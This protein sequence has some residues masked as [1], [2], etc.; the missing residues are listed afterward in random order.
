MVLDCVEIRPRPE[1]NVI[2]RG[3]T[4]LVTGVLDGQIE[5][6]S[7]HGL[8]VHETRMLSRYQYWI[9]GEPLNAVTL[10]NVNRSEWA[11]YYI[12]S[13]SRSKGH[14]PEQVIELFVHRFAG[15]GFREDL[16]IVN[17]TQ[18]QQ[19]FNFI[20][21]LKVDFADQDEVES[22][23]RKQYGTIVREWCKDPEP[24]LKFEYSA[25]RS[26]EHQGDFGE[27]T[28]RR[29]LKM[30][31][32]DA[33]SAPEYK[34]EKIIF[35]IELTPGASWKARVRF[36]PYIAD[37][38]EAKKT[39]EAPD[40]DRNE[41]AH[42]GTGSHTSAFEVP[43]SATLSA[44]VLETL[45][46][47]AGDLAALRLN[48]LDGRGRG[49]TVAAGYPNYVGLFGRDSLITGWLG[50]LF[51]SQLNLGALDQL[52]ERQGIRHDKW[53]DEQPMRIL[54]QAHTGP[55]AALY[56]NPHMH[57]Y[58][59]ITAPAYFPLSLVNLWRWTGHEETVS[60]FVDPA[61]KALRWL[62]EY[63][64]LRDDG[65]YYY[66]TL[67]EQGVKNQ[68]WKDSG[69]A[70]VH[71]DGS[72][73]E[74]PIASAEVQGLVYLAKVSTSE[75]LWNL[76]RT[77]E[78]RALYNQAQELKKR[79]NEGFWMPDSRFVAMGL[80]K[81]GRQIKS[82]SSNP[83]HC[84]TAGIVDSEIAREV[85]NRLFEEDMFSGWGMRTLSSRH[86]AY[87]PFSYQ[88]G[89]VWPF[90]QAMLGMGLWFYGHYDLL[91]RIA[92][93]HFESARLF[94]ERRLP[95]VFSGHPRDSDHPFPAIYPKAQWLQAWSAA[96]AFG[97]LQ[98]MLGIY[99]YAPMHVLMIDPHL[100]A[101]LPEITVSGL[102]VGGAEASLR[103]FRKEDSS[104]D[105]EVMEC[106]G[107]LRILRKPRA[108][109]FLSDYGQRAIEKLTDTLSAEHQVG[110]S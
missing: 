13:P 59:T 29:G 107:E 95:E 104:T 70:V 100:P 46:V 58:G 86:P 9:E 83:S 36:V 26:Y 62:D 65:F 22:G 66:K 47:G 78:A 76:H 53:R 20:I 28:V 98:A 68:G 81:N 2:A 8:F 96:S 38:D 84:L 77:D 12:H 87:N 109:A 75:L 72:Q 54:H 3:R 92:K 105:S 15:N 79:F 18:D 108:I 31:I 48:D 69:E 94:A 27:T 85:A 106:T 10:A 11:G 60:K 97:M 39:G 110:G 5:E 52:T 21:D 56:F 6:G 23:Q 90:E 91:E 89:T 49:W 4:V 43:G 44:T 67:S 73:A 16:E 34:V 88:R 55:L 102:K 25:S 99:P 71:E 40:L 19:C 14:K 57:Y 42:R 35:W 74:D 33:D 51:S 24:Q 37:D 80:D 82:I 93:T 61:L 17:F 50:Q 1:I 103:F 101:W 63:A 41:N 7:R 45:R 64:T 30:Q 32:A